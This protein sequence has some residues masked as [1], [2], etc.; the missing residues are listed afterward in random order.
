MILRDCA[1][2]ELFQR[3]ERYLCYPER[4]I[5]RAYSV[6][7]LIE[8]PGFPFGV[9][10]YDFNFETFFVVRLADADFLR[11]VVTRLALITPDKLSS[12]ERSLLN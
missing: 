2:H 1:N 5:R 3:I 4:D 6:A 7:T 12:L 8:L 9:F 11:S 10:S